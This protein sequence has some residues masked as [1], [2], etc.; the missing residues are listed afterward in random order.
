MLAGTE[1]WASFR[2]GLPSFGDEGL[3][4]GP[5]VFGFVLGGE[6]DRTDDDDR[7]DSVPEPDSFVGEL[8][9]EE[10]LAGDG[11][12][13]KTWRR[14]T[15]PSPRGTAPASGAVRAASCDST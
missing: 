4:A 2:L 1:V 8:T 3:P 5:T 9:G 11:P 10:P 14:C 7:K 15:E 6:V 13:P 12:R